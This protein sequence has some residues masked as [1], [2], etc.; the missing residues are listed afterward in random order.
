MTGIEYRI[1]PQDT[2][3]WNKEYRIMKWIPAPWAPL[4]AAFAGMTGLNIEYLQ[5]TPLILL[6]VNG[7]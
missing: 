1:S 2:L 4:K 6:G 3:R 7:R 5:R